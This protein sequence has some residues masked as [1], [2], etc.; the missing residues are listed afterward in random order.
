MSH[1]ATTQ[2]K[3]W[4]NM[5]NDVATLLAAY[6]DRWA[7]Y[8]VCPIAQHFRN[9]FAQQMLPVLLYVLF[10][11]HTLMQT[12]ACLAPCRGAL[13]DGIPADKRAAADAILD[14]IYIKVRRP[15][16]CCLLPKRRDISVQDGSDGLVC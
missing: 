3:P 1:G 4:G 2:R 14:D 9:P 13:L 10:V 11:Q 15:T 6:E 16:H 5:A 7:E 12:N 8:A